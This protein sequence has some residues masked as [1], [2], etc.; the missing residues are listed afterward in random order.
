MKKYQTNRSIQMAMLVCFFYLLPFVVSS[1][2]LVP[3]YGFD[4]VPSTFPCHWTVPFPDSFEKL[5][6]A[7]P[8]WFSPLCTTPDFFT[9]LAPN[10]CFSS[11]YSTVDNC[12]GWE[13]PR[14]GHCYV[15]FY[16]NAAGGGP[17]CE[18]PNPY[19]YKE[20]FGAELLEP[21]KKGHR[22][23]AEMYVSLGEFSFN[24]S[25][26][27]GIAFD[28]IK[29]SF[30]TDTCFMTLKAM[31]NCDSIIWDTSGWT[32]VSGFFTAEYDYNYLYIGNFFSRFDTYNP[33]T[34]FAYAHSGAYYFAE[35]VYVVEVDSAYI[36]ADTLICKGDSITIT[37]KGALSHHWYYPDTPKD[38]LSTTSSLKLKL[39]EHTTVVLKGN[40]SYDTI[41]I[42]VY[43]PLVNLDTAY[44]CLDSSLAMKL[45]LEIK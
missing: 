16:N 5:E 21:M 42:K 14:S 7:V 4:Q 27:L 6:T 12:V 38:T 45:F 35:D 17:E 13:A 30:R 41:H 39:E 19:D 23:Y 24:A 15:G 11:T 40:S 8:G 37:G 28:S 33:N 1:Q 25:N 36:I 9:D 26:N 18:C 32:K 10:T 20:Y 43:E 29:H 2:N 34:M 22:Y 3:N 31:V 44:Y